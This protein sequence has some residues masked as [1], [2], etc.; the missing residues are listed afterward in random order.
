MGEWTPAYWRMRMVKL[1]LCSWAFL[2][3]IAAC[4]VLKPRSGRQELPPNAIQF[5]VPKGTRLACF[6]G[7]KPFWYGE[8]Q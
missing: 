5:H 4:L 6:A 1:V 7:G 3:L 8:A 2:M